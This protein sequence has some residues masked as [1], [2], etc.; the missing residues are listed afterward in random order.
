MEKPPLHHVLIAVQR[1]VV[2]VVGVGG[3]EDIVRPG[4]GPYGNHHR[5]VGEYLPAALKPELDK[6]TRTQEIHV[7][8]DA[9]RPVGGLGPGHE[10]PEKLHSRPG[11]RTV[12]GVDIVPA[13]VRREVHNPAAGVQALGREIGAVPAD[14]AEII[15]GWVAGIGPFVGIGHRR[16]AIIWKQLDHAASPLS[17]HPMLAVILL[18]PAGKN[19]FCFVVF[20][21]QK[22]ELLLAFS[23]AEC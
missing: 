8:L 16:P 15:E 18:T 9:H 2:G 11:R 5:R 23:G 6:I 12:G 17:C 14:L 4:H 21:R 19:L 7:H 10:V 22:P 13:E 20:D 1:P 3:D